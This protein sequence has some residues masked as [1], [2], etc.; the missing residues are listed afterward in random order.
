MK[1][2]AYFISLL[3]FSILLAPVIQGQDIY[4]FKSVE[5]KCT[6]TFPGE[7]NID[8]DE[9][10][11]A[12]VVKVMCNTDS[13]TFLLS[14]SLHKNEMVDHQ[15][16]AEVSYDSFIEA[17]GGQELS[18]EEWEINGQKGLKATIE[19]PANNSKVDYR[20]ILVGEIQYQLASIASNQNYDE[21]AI[22]AFNDSFDF[23][24]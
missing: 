3:V 5:G 9:T 6:V 13:H 14:Y 20:V 11:Y 21:A 2:Y 22:A 8:S 7:Y 4:E 23:E 18:K 15:N 19:M 10:E 16:M 17:V 12:K 1:T 24:E